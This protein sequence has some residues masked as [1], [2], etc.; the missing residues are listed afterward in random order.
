[1]I[2]QDLGA[3]NHRDPGLRFHFVGRGRGAVFGG[4]DA[5]VAGFDVGK[6]RFLAA[7]EV[8]EI[9]DHLALQL[10]DFF[11]PAAVGADI[12]VA[13]DPVSAA[14]K[15]AVVFANDSLASIAAVARGG[16]LHAVEV[17]IDRRAGADLLER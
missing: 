6:D 3:V 4:G 8:L 10:G 5:N 17:A 7:G 11:G 1:E 15:V 14:E 9:I 16:E 13:A 2:G 12:P